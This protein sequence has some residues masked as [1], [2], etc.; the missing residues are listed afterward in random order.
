MVVQACVVMS[1]M[2]RL[3]LY[4]HQHFFM[5]GIFTVVRFPAELLHLCN[6]VPVAHN[7]EKAALEGDAQPRTHGDGQRG[8]G[9]R[10]NSQRKCSRSLRI[11]VRVDLLQGHNIINGFLHLVRMNAESRLQQLHQKQHTR[12]RTRHQHEAH[13]DEP[14]LVSGEA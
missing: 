10:G 2:M 8:H 1:E 11:G 13:R 12:F 5:L 14:H 6:Q 4:L 7:L 9:H 3:S